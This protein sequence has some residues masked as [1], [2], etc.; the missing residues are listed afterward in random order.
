MTERSI[1]YIFCS[2]QNTENTNSNYTQIKFK[3][4][5]GSFCL[6]RNSLSAA[7]C[8]SSP[9]NVFL[10][11]FGQNKTS[12]MFSFIPTSHSCILQVKPARSHSAPGCTSRPLSVK[13]I[14]QTKNKGQDYSGW[15]SLGYP[16][17]S[18]NS[19]GN[20]TGS[21]VPG[22]AS[23]AAVLQHHFMEH[24]EYSWVH[25]SHLYFP[26]EPT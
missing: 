20:S 4:E 3:P 2:I 16:E 8:R 11:R 23:S 12:K 6:L 7:A 21:F 19:G 26:R 9:F 25:Y 14:R 1:V 13:D 5:K 17:G 15:C 22:F 18:G 24:T 10:P